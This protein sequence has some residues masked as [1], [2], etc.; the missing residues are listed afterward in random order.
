MAAR[1]FLS[2]LLALDFRFFFLSCAHKLQRSCVLRQSVSKN[3]SIFFNQFRD[4]FR[5]EIDDEIDVREK[6]VY[7]VME[8]TVERERKDETII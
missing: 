3:F 6:V 4:Q 5:L 1:S 8:E 7:M 2:H